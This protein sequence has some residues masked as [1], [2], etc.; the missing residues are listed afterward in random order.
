MIKGRP[1]MPADQNFALCFIKVV[2]KLYGL[3]LYC[4]IKAEI[5]MFNRTLCCDIVTLST[6]TDFYPDRL[7]NIFRLTFGIWINP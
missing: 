1:T 3:D 6:D 5:I 2:L 7:N 4:D